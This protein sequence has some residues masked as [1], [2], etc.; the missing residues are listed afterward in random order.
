MCT[1]AGRF[2]DEK[3]VMDEATNRRLYEV[4]SE[5]D[6]ELSNFDQKGHKGRIKKAV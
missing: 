2:K 6:P 1:K 4:M 3:E 5:I